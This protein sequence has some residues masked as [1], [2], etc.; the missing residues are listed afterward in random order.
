MSLGEFKNLLKVQKVMMMVVVVV[1]CVCP[2]P[3]SI[4][5]V[6]KEVIPQ[7]RNRERIWHY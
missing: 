3:C 4:L 1:G 7:V 2:N 5:Y 6:A